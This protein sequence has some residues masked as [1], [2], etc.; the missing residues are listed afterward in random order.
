M[1]R[2]DMPWNAMKWDNETEY[3][4]MFIYRLLDRPWVFEWHNGQKKV[5]GS[6]VNGKYEGVWT[7]YEWDNKRSQHDMVIPY[8]TVIFF[9]KKYDI[10]VVNAH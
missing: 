3:K 2:H 7:I 5:E 4:N 10:C 1:K 9:I 8:R 6:Y